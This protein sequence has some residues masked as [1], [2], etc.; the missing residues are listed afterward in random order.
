MAEKTFSIEKQSK[1]EKSYKA[2]IL[3]IINNIEKRVKVVEPDQMLD[4]ELHKKKYLDARRERVEFEPVRRDICESFGVPFDSEH[5]YFY[6]D[7]VEAGPKEQRALRAF[8]VLIDTVRKEGF[9]GEGRIDHNTLFRNIVDLA[10]KFDKDITFE[11]TVENMD[12]DPPAYLIFKGFMSTKEFREISENSRKVLET[13]IVNDDGEKVE[14]AE[15]WF[16]TGHNLTELIKGQQGS[17][18]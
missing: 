8:F 13:P 4:R 17:I 7:D 1:S 2:Q 3:N 15:D 9:F 11:S 16:I 18:I 5:M 6:N 14:T 10:K 12:A